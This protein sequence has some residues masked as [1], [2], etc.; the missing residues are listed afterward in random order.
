[1]N[2]KLLILLL[3]CL[4]IYPFSVEAQDND[5]IKQGKVH[6]IGISDL[7]L[8]DQMMKTMPGIG[9]NSKE[10]LLKQN[11]K[12]Y[13][14]PIREL[15]IRGTEMSYALA[16]CLEYYINLGSNY[17]ANLSPDYI[18][19]SLKNAGKKGSAA[20]GLEFL[21]QEGTVSAAILP[22][23]ASMLTSAVYATQKYKI[24][25]YLQMF[26]QV[27]KPRQKVFETRKALMRGN[28]VIIEVVGGDDFKKLDHKRF[29]DAPKVDLE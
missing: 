16:I 21:V 15:G 5:L 25:N 27:T 26:R 29:F 10:L 7:A 24:N 1:M 18:S 2:C 13:M 28:P 22:Y 4:F 3:V 11:I 9:S 14:M 17:K 6:G 20:D 8:I 23:D 12:S 19:L